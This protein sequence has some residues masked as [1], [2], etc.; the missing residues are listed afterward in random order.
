MESVPTIAIAV[1]TTL[2]VKNRDKQEWR[3]N[4]LKTKRI[5]DRI[6]YGSNF[7]FDPRTTFLPSSST[8]SASI[9]YQISPF[10]NLGIGT[11]YVQPLPVRQSNKETKIYFPTSPGYGIRS[12]IDLKMYKHIYLQVGY[13]RNYRSYIQGLVLS[14]E[15]AQLSCLQSGLVGLKIRYPVKN[16]LSRPTLEML[17]DFLSQQTGQPA[18]MLRT[19][20]EFNGKHALKR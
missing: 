5:V 10:S 15:N 11:S 20:I 19:G 9:S 16:K 12:S 8:F 13:E 2:Q 1:D 18:F 3:P 14:T 17:Y 6:N 7:Q 4:P